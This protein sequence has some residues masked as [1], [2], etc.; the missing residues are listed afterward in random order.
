MNNV[1][2][3]SIIIPAFKA[4]LYIKECLDSIQS[5]TYFSENGNYENQSVFTPF[6][7]QELV[8]WKWVS[9]QKLI[10]KLA[11]EK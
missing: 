10:M 5:Q 4:S 2:K 11:L 6:K 7:P 1:E 3:I 9:K 8:T